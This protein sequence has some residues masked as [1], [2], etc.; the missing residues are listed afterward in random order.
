MRHVLHL[1]F[2]PFCGALDLPNPFCCRLSNSRCAIIIFSMFIMLTKRRDFGIST[3]IYPCAK[4]GFALENTR[5]NPRAT[6]TI[7]LNRNAFKQKSLSIQRGF[8][9]IFKSTVIS[10]RGEPRELQS[11]DQQRRRELQSQCC[12]CPVR[13]S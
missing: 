5:I 1:C 6:T 8:L 10:S 13:R 4:R 7:E 3:R 2:E 9:T 11:S 12:C